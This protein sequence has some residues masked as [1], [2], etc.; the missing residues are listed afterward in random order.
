MA[1]LLVIKIINSIYLLYLTKTI[2]R[3]IH[4]HIYIYY[5]YCRGTSLM[6]RPVTDSS[7][8]C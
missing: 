7:T 4:T 2:K 1:L 5:I 3:N 6:D 8:S